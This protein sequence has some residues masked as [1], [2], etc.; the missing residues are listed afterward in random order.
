VSALSTLARL[1]GVRQ[2]LAE[3]ALHSER[4]ACAAL[5]RRGLLAAAG[6]LATGSVFSF[7]PAGVW[8]Q[9]PNLYDWSNVEVRIAGRLF[10]GLV[11][12]NFGF[13]FGEQR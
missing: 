2:D 10:P 9:N 12:I 3:D 5:S 6:A 4:A 13:H 1:L 11:H 8:V 7:A